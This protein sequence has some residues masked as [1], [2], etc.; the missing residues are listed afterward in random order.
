M[1]TQLRFLLPCTT[2]RCLAIHSAWSEFAAATLCN[3]ISSICKQGSFDKR[4]F[5]ARWEWEDQ[6]DCPLT[7][8]ELEKK[9]DPWFQ[10]VSSIWT[11]VWVHKVTDADLPKRMPGSCQL[12]EK[13]QASHLNLSSE[14]SRALPRSPKSSAED[15]KFKTLNLFGLLGSMLGVFLLLCVIR[16]ICTYFL[17]RSKRYLILHLPKRRKFDDHTV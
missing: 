15:S 8:T 10:S 6:R 7:S 11:D 17:S 13:N 2:K 9:F 3:Q 16:K 14:A 1:D 4:Y 12:F 5:S